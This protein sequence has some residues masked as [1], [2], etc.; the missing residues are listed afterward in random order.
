MN[1]FLVEE[2]RERLPEFVQSITQADRRAGRNMYICPLCGSGTGKGNGRKDGAFSIK[3]GKQWH[4]FACD[5]GGS[6]YDLIG[7]YYGLHDFKD[8]LNKAAIFFGYDINGAD[9]GRSSTVKEKAIPTQPSYNNSPEIKPAQLEAI[10]RHIEQCALRMEGSPGEQYMKGRGFTNDTIKAFR[11]GYDD[12]C[13]GVVIPYPGKDYYITRIIGAS[14]NGKYRKPKGLAE[15]LFIAGNPK[16]GLIVCEGQL[17]ALTLLQEGAD[18]VAAIGGGGARKLENID[19]IKK[20]A[21][22]ADNDKAGKETAVRIKE[23]LEEQNIVCKITRPTE[24]KDVNEALKT[25][26]GVAKVKSLID[27]CREWF[28]NAPEVASQSTQPVKHFQ[29]YTVSDYILSGTFQSDIDYFKEYK[30]RKT[31]FK[32]LDKYLTLYPGLAALGGASSLGKTTFAV[33]LADRLLKRGETVIYFSLEQLP[34]ELISKSLAR[35]LIEKD[36]STTLT[37]IDIKNGATSDVLEAIKREYVDQSQNYHIVTGNFHT[38]VQDI[39]CYVEDFI[40]KHVGIKPIVIVD[41]L[42]LI[43]PP[44]GFWGS[45]R[46]YTDENIKALKDMQKENELFVIMISSFNRSNNYE[47]VA[48]ETFKETSM[49]EYTCDYVWGLQLSILDAENDDFY[50]KTGTQGGEKESLIRERR[51]KVQ[52]AMQQNPKKVEFVSLKNR[53]GRQVFKVFFNYLP[54]YDSFVE[55][56]DFTPITKDQ[57]IFKN[58]PIFK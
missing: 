47:P 38:T 2:M 51:K 20:A 19:G 56:N 1:D 54:Q 33:N 40:K 13:N 4:C 34:I 8:Q 18:A 11:I 52:E 50:V 10:Q 3:D 7:A 28:A 6:I 39:K 30:D 21:I 43:A 45:I 14:G 37:N 15:P 41:Y 5:Q 48:Y 25:E 32:E 53:N 22:I 31:G 29:T 57:D 36:P 12:A 46:E 35:M 24:E 17:D 9:Y 42:Q 58:L 55:N 49:I 23:T 44:E 27:Q 26:G 16:A